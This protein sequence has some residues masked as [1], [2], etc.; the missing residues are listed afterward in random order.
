MLHSEKSFTKYTGCF[1]HLFFRDLLR[2]QSAQ[3]MGTFFNLR[4]LRSALWI[5]SAHPHKEDRM[6]FLNF[7][8]R[9]TFSPSCNS[10]L[11]FFV[12]RPWTFYKLCSAKRL[13]T[14]ITRET[15]WLLH[16]FSICH[17]FVFIWLFFL[18]K[19]LSGI[20]C[21]SHPNASSFLLSDTAPLWQAAAKKTAAARLPQKKRKSG[22]SFQRIRFSQLP[23][24]LG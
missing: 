18:K 21:S 4:F 7:Q 6:H 17:S 24:W 23:A 1:F 2:S 8:K 12:S 15:C 19:I 20:F 11:L 16:V 5:L 22:L 10:L 9:T 13:Y 3:Q 14:H